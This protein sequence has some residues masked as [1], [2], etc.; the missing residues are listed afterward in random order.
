MYGFRI[1]HVAITQ[2]IQDRFQQLGNALAVLKL[3]GHALH[4]AM[5]SDEDLIDG[6]W[7]EYAAVFGHL[8]DDSRCFMITEFAELDHD[9]SFPDRLAL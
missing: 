2:G 3:L 8:L 6:L 9:V 1:L 4:L 7:I 5:R